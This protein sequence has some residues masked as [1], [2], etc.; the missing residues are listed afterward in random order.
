MQGAEKTGVF[1]NGQQLFVAIVGGR[2]PASIARNSGERPCGL[3]NGGESDCSSRDNCDRRL[4][5][6]VPESFEDSWALCCTLSAARV[7]LV[8]DV[9]DCFWRQGLM[10]EVHQVHD[11]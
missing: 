8:V 11:R 7:R 9:A 2:E 10:A 6:I 1:I 3:P 5:A 4:A